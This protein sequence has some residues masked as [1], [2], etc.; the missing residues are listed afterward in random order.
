M[1][2]WIRSIVSYWLRAHPPCAR[3]PA[4]KAAQEAER[5]ARQR[6]NT[7]GIGRALAAKRAALHAD[8]ER[9]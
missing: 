7:R 6:N 5:R 3:I 4:W 9:A 1:N 8:L 2:R